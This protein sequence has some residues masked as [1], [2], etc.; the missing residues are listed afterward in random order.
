[1][2]QEEYIEPPKSARRKLPAQ[3][4]LPGQ[5]KKAGGI[6]GGISGPITLTGSQENMALLPAR[7]KES[8][9][10]TGAITITG[11]KGK[12]GVSPGRLQA[13]TIIGS[14]KCYRN[15]TV[16][17]GQGGGCP[18]TNFT[19]NLY[20]LYELGPNYDRCARKRVRDQESHAILPRSVRAQKNQT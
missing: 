11:Q 4:P 9:P 10:I 2:R 14:A 17:G 6:P 13:R 8:A 15:T 12:V 20:N 3:W 1:M 16:V 5:K 7:K 19:N 18:I